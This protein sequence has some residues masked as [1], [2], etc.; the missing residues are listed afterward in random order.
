[1]RRAAAAL[2]ASL[3][4]RAPT[5]ASL[6]STT[7][8]SALAPELSTMLGRVARGQVGAGGFS[9]AAGRLSARAATSAFPRPRPSPPPARP[10][11]SATVASASA[12]RPDS[13]NAMAAAAEDEV[14][15]VT[16]EEEG[17]EAAAPPPPPAPVPPQLSPA[18]PVAAAI[19]AARAAAGNSAAAGECGR[20]P[21][22][23]P[24]RS[25]RLPA[26]LCSRRILRS[27]C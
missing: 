16:E 2:A 6:L 4:R 27:G 15:E 14:D 11:H 18:T 19:S 5:S 9:T 25:R 10:F 26:W 24:P 20:W 8:V 12:R 22:A 3:A 23:C 17:D 21:A 13:I 1:M 7:T